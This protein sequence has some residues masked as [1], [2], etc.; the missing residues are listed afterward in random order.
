VA[1]EGPL[2]GHKVAIEK[3]QFQIGAN[4][5]NDL[6]LADNYISGNHALLSFENGELFLC[7]LKS[8]NG[9]F[10]NEELVKDKPIAVVQGD[11]IRI[12]NSNLRVTEP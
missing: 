4:A 5:N 8:R 1:T 12:G 6:V 9:T 10:L 2:V 11:I 7:D 3:Q